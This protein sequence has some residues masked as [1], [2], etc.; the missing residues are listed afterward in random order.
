MEE[1]HMNVSYKGLNYISNP[2][3]EKGKTRTASQITRKGNPV[4]HK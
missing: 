4:P 1:G 3:I 2:C